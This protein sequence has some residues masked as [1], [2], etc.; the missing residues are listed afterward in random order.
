MT[1]LNDVHS[2]AHALDQFFKGGD[3]DSLFNIWRATMPI[4]KKMV[5]Q[6]G[7]H[8]FPLQQALSRRLPLQLSLQS[9]CHRAEVIDEKAP[10]EEGIVVSPLEEP[11]FLE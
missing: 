2:P 4:L 9:P 11:S 1:F 3:N 7:R 10:V 8:R 5:L 6:G